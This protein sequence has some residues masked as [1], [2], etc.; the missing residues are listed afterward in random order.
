[1]VL[2]F[3]R[4]ECLDGLNL[5]KHGLYRA[6]KTAKVTKIPSPDILALEIPEITKFPTLKPYEAP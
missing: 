2:T 5:D 6:S 1:M 3:L 4:L